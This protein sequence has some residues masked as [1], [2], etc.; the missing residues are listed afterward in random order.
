MA[1][2][3]LAAAVAAVALT[4]ACTSDQVV[5]TGEFAQTP[6]TETPSP[7]QAR[8][9]NV[10]LVDASDYYVVS[11][12][13]TG[14]YFTTPSGQWSCAIV[15]KVKAG[16]QA[17]GGSSLGIAGEPETVVDAEGQ[18]HTP[19]AILVTRDGDAHFA[20]LEETEFEPVPGSANVLELNKILAAAGFRCNVQEVGVSCLNEFNNKGFTFSAEGFT[21]SYTDVPPNPPA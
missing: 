4:V 10:N 3:G 1:R 18:S 7:E 21:L 19:N 8:P 20:W 6:V 11:D 17:A 2:W 14:Y 5:N 15:P 12:T 16:C 13:G 9:S